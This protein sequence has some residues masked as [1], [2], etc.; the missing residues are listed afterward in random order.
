MIRGYL[1]SNTPV[2]HAKLPAHEGV[3]TG[4]SALDTEGDI[5]VG[6]WEHSVGTSTGPACY[7]TQSPAV[8]CSECRRWRRSAAAGGHNRAIGAEPH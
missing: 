5:E 4:V 2:R 3:S 6:V 8:T 7:W 1:A